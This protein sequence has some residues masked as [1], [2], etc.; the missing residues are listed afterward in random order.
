MRNKIQITL[1]N[2]KNTW[3]SY[4]NYDTITR[5]LIGYDDHTPN[6][7]LEKNIGEF[8]NGHFQKYKRHIRI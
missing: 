6:F 2:S 4:W 8:V 5:Y 3:F 7:V 1:Y